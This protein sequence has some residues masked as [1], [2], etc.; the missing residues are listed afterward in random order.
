MYLIKV[1]EDNGGGN[2]N[3]GN[4]YASRYSPYHFI[5]IIVSRFFCQSEIVIKNNLTFELR[6]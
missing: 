4:Y 5:C 1:S 6:L 2:Y 3:N